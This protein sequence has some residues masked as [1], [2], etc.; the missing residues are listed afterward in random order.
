LEDV[1][2]RLDAAREIVR[3]A[4]ESG[5]AE[6]ALRGHTWR[7]V[8]F[9]ERADAVAADAEIETFAR[10][11]ADLR[12][13][14]LV[15][16][17]AA[18]RAMRALLSGRLCDAARLVDEA[19]AAS[20]HGEG[21]GADG[22]DW[23]G[24]N[25]TLTHGVQRF[26]LRTH[27]GRLGELEQEVRALAASYPT[28]PVWRCALAY[29][30]CSPE[31]ASEARALFDGLASADFADIPRDG[32]WL[33]AMA[34]LAEVCAFLGDTDRAVLLHGLLQPYAGRQ[35]VVGAAIVCRG[36]VEHYLGL[37]A[38]TAGA[39][40]AAE[41]YFAAALEMHERLGARIYAMRT[42]TEWGRTLSALGDPA[43]IT[44]ARD[45]LARA[46]EICRD[47]E[48]DHAGDLL[49][50]RLLALGPKAEDTPRGSAAPTP[51]AAKPAAKIAPAIAPAPE[52]G[53]APA[54]PGPIQRPAPAAF[55]REGEYW[56]FTF[57]GRTIRLRDAKGL[58][59]LAELLRSPGRELHAID[60]AAA[61]GQ[62]TGDLGDAGAVL[63]A[64][65]RQA[66]RLRVADLDEEIEQ[67]RAHGDGER[68]ARAE[69]ERDFIAHELAAGLGLGG[70]DR[71]AAAHSERA[72]LNVT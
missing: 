28:L 64:E 25:A 17:T 62:T 1:D 19:L 44:R 10:I 2:E 41:G 72:R 67:A 36:A 39:S 46:H 30:C 53:Q 8:A 48:L 37:L 59:Y 69:A 54:P 18:F 63:D 60:L 35:I 40:A 51:A 27:Q 16:Q 34:Q 24:P 3:L 20:P 68:S 57:G 38:A 11:A 55:I 12:Q 65:A 22:L 15:W 31:G 61:G 14:A 52:P 4:R 26:N 7:I 50:E 32:N 33:V 43:Q 71:R 21:R 58:R 5:D 29:L 56:T 42:L 66:Y 13:P 47:L 23:L 9:L 70:R 6:L 49:A 45:L